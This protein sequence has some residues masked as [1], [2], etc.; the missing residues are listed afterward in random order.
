MPIQTI[1]TDSLKDYYIGYGD[2]VFDTLAQIS[3]EGTLQV[4]SENN[5]LSMAQTNQKRISLIMENYELIDESSVNSFLYEK[6]SIIGLVNKTYS[7]VHE[8]IP[9]IKKITLEVLID[10]EDNQK[11]L[12]AKI[13]P[14]LPIDEALDKLD[15]FDKHWF[16]SNFIESDMIFNVSLDFEK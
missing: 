5:Y 14:D 1:Y 2:G 10:P 16:A 3:V 9:A 15:D 8:F 12:V 6:P 11:N 4:A 7:K 13:Y